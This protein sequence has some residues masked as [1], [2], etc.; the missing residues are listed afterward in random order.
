MPLS[1]LPPP[2]A[3]TVTLAAC[4]A[5]LA[6][7]LEL[8]EHGFDVLVRTHVRDAH[9]KGTRARAAGLRPKRLARAKRAAP[10]AAAPDNTA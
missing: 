8:L 1:P 2:P 7:G 4:P 9:L 3:V 6:R 5:R 10:S